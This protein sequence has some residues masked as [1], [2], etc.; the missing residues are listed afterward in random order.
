MNREMMTSNTLVV[1]PALNEAAT[2]GRVIDQVKSVGLDLVVVDDGSVDETAKIA[3]S[4]DVPLLRFVSNQ[5]VGSALR[6]GFRWAL[7]RGYDAVLQV[8]GDGQHDPTLAED[9]FRVASETNADLVIGSRFHSQ[10]GSFEASTARRAVMRLMASSVSLRARYP[11]TDVT[12]GFRLIRQPLL[13][14]FAE[15]LPSYYLGDTF[16]AAFVAAKRG[17]IVREVPVSM[18]ARTSGKSS[19]SRLAATAMIAKT[20]TVTTLG[21]HFDIPAR[22]N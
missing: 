3:R 15:T 11:L 12:S 19:A 13:G 22:A 17:Y 1:I 16:E 9:L 8:D 5:G 6:C 20:F 18:E 4:A 21:L 10:S 2:I 7:D 14:H